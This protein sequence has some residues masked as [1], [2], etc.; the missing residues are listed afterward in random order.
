MDRLTADERARLGSLTARVDCDRV[1]LH[2]VSRPGAAGA[3]RGVILWA[4]RHRAVALGN[5]V[6]LPDRCATDL[7][8][9][10]HELTHCGQ[11]QAWG[12]VALLRPRRL[13]PAPRAPV[14]DAS[15]G[16]EPLSLPARGRE[17]VRGLRHGTARAD[18]RGLLPWRPGG[19]GRVAVPPAGSG[20]SVGLIDVHV[21]LTGA[22]ARWSRG[23]CPPTAPARSRRDPPPSP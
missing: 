23:A 14:P 18:R 12:R 22:R 20:R 21:G 9:L 7:A 10:A 1:R 6:F 8:T 3:L 2:R 13:R 16:Q 15:R 11:Y 5:H 19:A 17:A 4:S